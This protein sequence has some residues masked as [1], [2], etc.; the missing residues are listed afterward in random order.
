M[1]KISTFS[2]GDRHKTKLEKIAEKYGI[3]MSEVL[4]RLI[5]EKFEQL[6]IPI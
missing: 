6:A 3:K 4:R 2:L 1:S 5:D